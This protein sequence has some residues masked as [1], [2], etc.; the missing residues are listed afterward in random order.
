[1]EN[2]ADP[3]RAQERTAKNVLQDGDLEGD[4][5]MDSRGSEEST[6]SNETENSRLDEASLA[7]VELA[8]K[9]NGEA[10]QISELNDSDQIEDQIDDQVTKRNSPDPGECSDQKEEDD[11]KT[12]EED[13]KIEE[14]DQKA[15]EK[16]DQ[17]E[18]EVDQNLDQ[19]SNHPNSDQESSFR[20]SLND[21]LVLEDDARTAEPPDEQQLNIDKQKVLNHPLFKL[22]GK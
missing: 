21:G 3:E 22:L 1:M 11:Q 4:L 12:K 9:T 8:S 17:R 16:E 19:L 2:P 15:E 14:N 20:F 6:R 5:I 13:Q 7:Q 10:N 18:D